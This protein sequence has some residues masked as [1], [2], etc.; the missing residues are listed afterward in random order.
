[1]VISGNRHSSSLKEKWRQLIE[2]E[3]Q[4]LAAKTMRKRKKSW[5][6]KEIEQAATRGMCERC[7]AATSKAK[8]KSNEHQE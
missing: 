8:I 3:E 2:W 1:M 4:I 7:S 5:I 6:T